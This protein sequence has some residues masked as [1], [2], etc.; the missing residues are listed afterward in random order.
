M[1]ATLR[2]LEGKYYG[3]EIELHFE[4]GEGKEVIK[5]WNSGDYTP[6][7]REIES[8]GYTPEQWDDNEIVDDGDG[9]M[10]QIRKLGL[11]CDSHF[12]SKLT[13]ERAI[14]IVN[15]INSNP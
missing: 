11:I 3:T 9:T 8:W 1:R 10:V 4:D 5:F 13:Y 12:E 14:K 7:I 6:S 15:V 2:P